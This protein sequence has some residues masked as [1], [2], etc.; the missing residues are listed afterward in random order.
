VLEK[1]QTSAKDLDT[2]IAIFDELASQA[3]N[4]TIDPLCRLDSMDTHSMLFNALEY[5]D[6]P[7]E[8][9]GMFAMHIGHN[10]LTANPRQIYTDARIY[11][12]SHFVHK[13]LE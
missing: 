1:H 9:W 6:I 13:R 10:Y 3:G 4:A 8:D 11:Y 2:F 5:S 7:D 12:S